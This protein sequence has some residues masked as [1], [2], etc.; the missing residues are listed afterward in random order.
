MLSIHILIAV[1]ITAMLSI[2]ILIAVARIHILVFI[3]STIWCSPILRIVCWRS[4]CRLFCIRICK[5]KRRTIRISKWYVRWV[6]IG[7]IA[8]RQTCVWWITK[9]HSICLSVRSA[10]CLELCYSVILIRMAARKIGKKPLWVWSAYCI[11]QRAQFRSISKSKWEFIGLKLVRTAGLHNQEHSYLCPYPGK[12]GNNSCN[13]RM[14]HCIEYRC[15]ETF[16]S[17]NKNSYNAKQNM[18]DINSQSYKYYKCSYNKVPNWY[19]KD[20]I[21]ILVCQ[22]SKFMSQRRLYLFRR[23][24]HH[25]LRDTDCLSSCCKCIRVLV[26]AYVQ[27]DIVRNRRIQSFR[28]LVHLIKYRHDK[29]ELFCSFYL[30]TPCLKP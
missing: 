26:I 4:L 15:K 18:G 3:Y 21:C 24:V 19:Y 14:I 7:L 20:Q 6:F 22:V 16:W 13:H 11:Q 23:H 1:W 17:A 28:L 25:S 5:S 2:H 12:A 8:V 30:L 10:Q 27:L 29:I 9:P